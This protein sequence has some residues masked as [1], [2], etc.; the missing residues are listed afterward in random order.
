MAKL[1]YL[2]TRVTNQNL[3]NN[4]IRNTLNL[5]LIREEMKCRLNFGNA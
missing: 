2:R 3:I 5:N 4:E 1:K